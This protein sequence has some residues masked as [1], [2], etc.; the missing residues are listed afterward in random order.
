MDTKSKHS[1][2]RQVKQKKASQNQEKNWSIEIR[3]SNNKDD[4]LMDKNF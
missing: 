1:T 3:H 4:R 2:T